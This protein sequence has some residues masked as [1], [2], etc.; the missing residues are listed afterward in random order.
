MFAIEWDNNIT[1]YDSF[2][3]QFL[4]ILQNGAAVKQLC[5]MP[6]YLTVLLM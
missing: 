1:H 4:H 2:I 5:F 3:Q 6:L